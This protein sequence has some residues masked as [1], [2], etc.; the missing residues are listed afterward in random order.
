MSPDHLLF[1]HRL[2]RVWHGEVSI[3]FHVQLGLQA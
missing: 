1:M 3:T 2:G